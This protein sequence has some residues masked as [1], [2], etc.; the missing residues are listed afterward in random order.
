LAS[1]A[2]T[3]T[4]P[5]VFNVSEDPVRLGLVTR[6]RTAGRQHDRGQFFQRLREMA[7][8]GRASDHAAVRGARSRA[9]AC[10]WIKSP[11]R[12]ARCPAPR[13]EPLQG[14]MDRGRRLVTQVAF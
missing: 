13:H 12:E 1:K 8:R 9:A 4:I 5:V 11:F 2:A 6:P 10:R 7:V 3:P 14:M